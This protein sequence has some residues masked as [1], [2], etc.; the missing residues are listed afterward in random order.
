MADKNPDPEAHL[1]NIIRCQISVCHH[2]EEWDGSDF[3][4]PDV[5]SFPCPQ[6]YCNGRMTMRCGGLKPN[7]ERCP[8]PVKPGQ[9][10]R[11]HP[12][13][14]SKPQKLANSAKAK[15]AI[16]RLPSTAGKGAKKKPL[17]PPPNGNGN[18]SLPPG[19]VV[20]SQWRGSYDRAR[21][22]PE[23]QGT[24]IHDISLLRSQQD[25]LNEMLETGESPGAWKTLQGQ[26]ATLRKMLGKI[27]EH[28]A[29]GEVAKANEVNRSV[30]AMLADDLLPTIEQGVGSASIR[31]EMRQIT[32]RLEG[33]QK[34]KAQMEKTYTPPVIEAM[35]QRTMIMLDELIA[36]LIEETEGGPAKWVEFLLSWQRQMTYQDRPTLELPMLTQ[37]IETTADASDDAS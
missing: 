21:N 29:A 16:G 23:A 1:A 27:Q 28:A 37:V 36:P 4:D 9:G 31:S 18:G 13:D 3:P 10:C 24:F 30:L 8:L 20:A 25:E 17:P 6:N 15:K 35:L 7:G 11:Y 26:G 5:M 14:D 19:S 2:T 32:A 34:A 12:K 22:D 33:V